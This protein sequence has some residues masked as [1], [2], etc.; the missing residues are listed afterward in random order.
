M[1]FSCCFHIYIDWFAVCKLIKAYNMHNVACN[2]S[3]IFGI[4]DVLFT[5]C[6]NC[7]F[8]LV[9]SIVPLLKG[10]KETFS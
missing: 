2:N 6:Q 10:P 3:Y 7:P 4:S 1:P 9:L 8:K 5:I